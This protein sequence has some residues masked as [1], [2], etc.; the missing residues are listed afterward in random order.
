MLENYHYNSCCC[1]YLGLLGSSGIFPKEQVTPSK[2]KS[3][4]RALQFLQFQAIQPFA[5][6]LYYSLHLTF[7]ASLSMFLMSLLRL[8]L[9]LEQSQLVTSSRSFSLPILVRYNCLSFPVL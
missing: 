3:L 7:S 2:L 9:Q 4:G 8:Q 1:V 5:K 6:A